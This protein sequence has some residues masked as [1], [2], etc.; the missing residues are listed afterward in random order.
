[1]PATGCCGPLHPRREAAKHHPTEHLA[2]L[3]IP[4]LPTLQPFL[5]FH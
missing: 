1:M 4:A 3:F 2:A 5:L